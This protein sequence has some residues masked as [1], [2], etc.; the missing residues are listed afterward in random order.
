VPALILQ[1]I[2]ENAVKYGVAKSR[3]PVT[4]RIS[5]YEE[6][7]RLHIKVKDDGEAAALGDGEGGTGVGLKNVS[8]RL[9]ARYGNRGG[10]LNGADPDGG[11]TVHIFMPV[12]RNG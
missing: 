7:G 10:C 4:I 6:A 3:K 12:M 8:E 1:P 9:T 5:A 11:Y 2:V